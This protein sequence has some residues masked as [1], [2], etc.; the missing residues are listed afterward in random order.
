MIHFQDAML[1]D[2]MLLEVIYFTNIKSKWTWNEIYSIFGP[3]YRIFDT[4]SL[5][6]LFILTS[7]FAFTF[8]QLTSRIRFIKPE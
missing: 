1:F 2:D 3:V 8:L 7:S 6:H 5:T 4:L